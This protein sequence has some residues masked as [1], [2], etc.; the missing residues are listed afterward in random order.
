MP[1]AMQDM[2]NRDAAGRKLRVVPVAIEFY[3]LLVRFETLP[4]RG[5]CKSPQHAIFKPY[6]LLQFVMNS[7]LRDCCFEPGA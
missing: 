6:V 3:E 2:A 4:R 7:G 1:Q 5:K